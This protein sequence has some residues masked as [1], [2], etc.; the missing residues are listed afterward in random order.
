[1]FG[2]FNNVDINQTLPEEAGPLIYRG[3]N[4]QYLGEEA[5]WRITVPQESFIQITF[6]EFSIPT[7]WWMARSGR[8]WE[9][10]QLEVRKVFI[11][12]VLH[13]FFR[14]KLLIQIYDGFCNYG[15]LSSGGVGGISD[16]T[17]SRSLCGSELPQPWISLTNTATLRLTATMNDQSPTFLIRWAAVPFYRLNQTTPT[18]SLYS[19]INVGLNFLDN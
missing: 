17:P 13:Y 9:L 16:C 5:W 6:D 7:R 12:V 8:C 11:F 2:T 10:L 4:Q 18:K 19:L 14:L 3:R 15:A 1:M